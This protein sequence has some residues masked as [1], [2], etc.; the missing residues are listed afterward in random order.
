VSVYTSCFATSLPQELEW[1]LL[2]VIAEAWCIKLLLTHKFYG[3]PFEVPFIPV[4][5]W[6][7]V[8]WD[9][10]QFSLCLIVMF[11]HRLWFINGQSEII[12]DECDN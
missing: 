4:V 10:M 3:I 7:N 1:T 6:I 5:C 12:N 2:S 8:A 9:W 11:N